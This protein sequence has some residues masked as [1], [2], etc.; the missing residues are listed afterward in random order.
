MTLNSFN[1]GSDCRVVLQ[2]P[3]APG[4]QL[5]FGDVTNFKSE[6]QTKSI[7]Y[8]RMDG[9][10]KLGEFPEGWSGSFDMQRTGSDVDD[11]MATLE[12]SI[13]NNQNPGPGTIFQYVNNP[14]GSTSTYQYPDAVFKFSDAGT[15]TGAEAVKQTLNFEAS[16]RV[17]V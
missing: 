15:Y 13:L 7:K 12:Q 5:N 8:T 9:K 17:R 2:H 6:Q 16:T 11:F 1:I 4:G 3:L 14:N 10:T